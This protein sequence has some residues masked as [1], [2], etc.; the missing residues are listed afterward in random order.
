MPRVASLCLPDFA[1]DRLRR[2]DRRTASRPLSPAPSAPPPEAGPYLR[3]EAN[4]AVARGGGWRPGARWARDEGVPARGDAARPAPGLPPLVT[5]RAEGQKI[6]LAAACPAARALGLAPGMAMTQARAMVPGLDVRPADPPGEMADLARLATHAARHWTPLAAPV[7]DREIVLDITGSA[8]LFGGEERLCRRILHLCR[9]LGLAA[10]IAVADTAAAAR[11]L[12]AFGAAR[13]ILCPPGDAE[14][15]TAALPVAALRLPPETVA[16]LARLGVESVGA[17]G[18][19][20]RA[21]LARRF[22]RDTL[23]ALDRLRGAMPDPIDPL[24]PAEAPRVMH[25][26]AEPVLTAE[27]IADATARLVEAMIGALAERGLGARTLLLEC[28]RIDHDRQRIAIGLARPSRDAAHIRRLLGLRLEEIAPGFGIE[29]MALTATRADALA[30]T[31]LPGALTGEPAVPPLATLVDRLATRLGDRRLY[32]LGMMESE[33]PERAQ[34]R[35]RPLA[36]P[37][38]WPDDWPRPVRLLDPAEPVDQVLAE[39]PDHPPRR[40]R[41]RG[42]AYRVVRGDGPER[43]HGEWWRN[44]AEADAVRDYFQVEDEAGHRF[45]IFRRGDGVDTRTGDMSWHMHGLFG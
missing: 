44:A 15:A 18:A 32:R 11:A 26:F 33:L 22:G 2:L 45:W 35:H 25:R 17:L 41:W 23:A 36:H 3:I 43:V 40:F 29:A 42:Q 12:A 30:S 27:G 28:V 14:Q 21:P 31:A 4:H 8:H 38:C 10:H 20:P 19:M 39:L 1:T 13:L 24:V 34:R 7:G 9:R 37:P 5:V 16:G 6:V